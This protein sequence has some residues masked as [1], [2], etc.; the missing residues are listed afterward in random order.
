LSIFFGAPRFRL[1]WIL[2]TIAALASFCSV[3]FRWSYENSYSNCQITLDYDDTR[4]LADAYQIPHKKLLQEFKDRGVTSIGLYEQNL[5]TLRDNARISIWPREEAEQLYP[6]TRWTNYGSAYRY[7]I[8]AT[9][10][11]QGLLNQVLAH[12]KVQSQPSLPPK[13]VQ[14][15][16]AQG[17]S[18]HPTA[19]FGILIPASR[20]LFSDAQMGFD[21]AQVK[22]VKD[23]GL[24]VTARLSNPLNLNLDRLRALLDEAQATGAHVV[25]F[26]EDEVLGYQSMIK[27]VAREMR[28]RELLFGNIEFSKQRGWDDFSR[29]T[30]GMLVRVHSVGGD[31]VAKA[32]IEMLIDRYARAVKER[33]IRV[34]YIRLIRQAKGDYAVEP[35]AANQTPGAT[36]TAPGTANVPTSTANQ[37]QI[38]TKQTP[39]EQNLDF[40][41]EISRELR[42]QPI[43]RAP[44]LRPG[45][46][47]SGARG[48]HDYPVSL[49]EPKVGSERKAKI[50]RSLFLFLA[51]LGAVGGTLLLLNLFF[52]LSNQAQ[53]GWAAVGIL[54]V[55]GLALSPGMGAKLM[56][57][58]V[59][60]LFSF[61]GMMWGGLPTLWDDRGAAVVGLDGKAAKN[62]ETI[63]VGN[64]IGR[65]CMILL[66]TTLLTMIGPLLIIALL[67]YWKFFSGA[68]KFLLPKATQLLPLLLVGMAFAGEVFPHRVVVEGAYPARK[69][70]LARLNNV[71][72][73]PFTARIALIALALFVLG[74][75]WIAR[76]GNDSGM[77]ISPIELKFRALLERV[78]VTR[79]RTKEIFMGHPAIMFA[80]WYALRRQR[81]LALA[82]VILTTIGQAD[83]LNT[84]CHIHTPIFYSLLRTIHGVWLGALVGAVAL[85]IYAPLESWWLN[86]SSAR[87][88]GST[89]GTSNGL[90]T[91][92]IPDG[93]TNGKVYLQEADVTPV[94]PFSKS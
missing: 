41:S 94:K 61:I 80:V 7:L 26:S 65:G 21:P 71:L 38:T 31:E 2:I 74:S 63:S 72:S 33:N 81:L 47:M 19:Q 14:T 18:H 15:I 30:E 8:T 52:D 35:T 11:N 34:A 9:P 58:Q 56:A 3:L 46:V 28:N 68:D 5:S 10:D 73:H 53:I 59:G 42:S 48:F 78:F 32:K 88:S 40:I 44:W 75:L 36:A 66:K 25:I 54:L 90:T 55:A 49:L 76:T 17:G 84:F 45:L 22:A 93:S 92:V 37:W 85:C 51:G 24:Q 6:G 60:C 12:L 23:L 91:A 57:L 4:A 79:P 29:E 64:A 50:V 62:V 82:A 77:E 69:R 83:V 89:N 20:Q 70:A 43:S 67:N 87:D 1:G 39:L 16:S 27:I 13:V 86:R